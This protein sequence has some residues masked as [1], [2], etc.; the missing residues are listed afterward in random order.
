VVL[1]WDEQAL[2]AIRASRPAP[3][4][5]ARALAVLHTATYDAWAAYDAT[6]VGT[7][8][9]GSLRRPAEERTANYKSKAISYAA[10]RALLDLFP[11]R[12]A[13]ITGFMGDLGYDP[14]DASTDPATPP[15]RR[16]PGR[17]GRARAPPPRRRQPA[18]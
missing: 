14:A 8:L 1:K 12:S 10:Y 11:T 17:Q 7:R 6:A 5:A 18:R 4:V 2:A 13:D 16:Q 3:T 15:G 9:G